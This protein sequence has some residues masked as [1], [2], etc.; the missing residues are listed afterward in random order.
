MK[1][2]LL[3]LAGIG[4]ALALC[5][6]PSAA[7]AQSQPFLGQIMIFAGN[8]CP[9]GWAQ[10][11]GQFLQISQNQALFSVLGTA[12]GG[13]GRTTFELPIMKPII[14]VSGQPFT[15]CIALLGVFP[16]QN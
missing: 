10:T 12:Y 7:F 11:N 8:F 5:A 9:N 16:A 2:R 13:D 14:T 15:T 6:S 1:K 3:T 4:A